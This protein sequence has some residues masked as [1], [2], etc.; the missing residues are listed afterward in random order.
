VRVQNF[1]T[2]WQDGLAFCAVAHQYA[3]SKIDFGSL[4]AAEDCWDDN[5][6]VQSPPTLFFECLCFMPA[7]RC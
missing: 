3:P 6:Q 7:F 2:S 1:T 5:L 4:D